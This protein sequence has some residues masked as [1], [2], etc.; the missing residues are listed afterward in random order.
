M[1]EAV[2]TFI[3]KKI[4]K[5]K[6]MLTSKSFGFDFVIDKTHFTLKFYPTVCKYT[7]F[8]KLYFPLFYYQNMGHFTGC[9]KYIILYEF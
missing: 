6:A 5:T 7:G 1:K 8:I 9:K 2:V 4:T 3:F